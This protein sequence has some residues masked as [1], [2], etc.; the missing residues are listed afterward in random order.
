MIVDGIHRVGCP[1]IPILGIQSISSS[2]SDISWIHSFP[3]NRFPDWYMVLNFRKDLFS[4]ET[5]S[6]IS[7]SS[8]FHN[9]GLFWSLSILS[10]LFCLVDLD[11]FDRLDLSWR[12]CNV[13]DIRI[14][15]DWDFFSSSQDPSP[16]YIRH[17]LELIEIETWMME[18]WSSYRYR[19][20]FCELT[21]FLCSWSESCSL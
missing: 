12:S 8:I 3:E 4:P 16:S 13:I 20:W 5:S 18:C 15:I 21:W 11:S 9:V 14:L 2:R 7:S 6:L 1:S 10:C 17:I 19:I